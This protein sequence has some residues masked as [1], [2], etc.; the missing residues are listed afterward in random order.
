MIRLMR[1]DILSGS[2]RKERYDPAH[3]GRSCMIRLMEEE[4]YDPAHGGGELKI[5]HH[6]CNL[7]RPPT[8]ETQIAMFHSVSS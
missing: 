6:P 5:L 7:T 1:G 4:M 2:C 8:M 3:E